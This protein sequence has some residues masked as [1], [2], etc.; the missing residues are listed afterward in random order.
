MGRKRIAV[1]AP[2]GTLYH[3]TGILNAVRCFAEA[4]YEVEIFT[5]RNRSF[6]TPSFSSES[7]A[8]RYMPW[9]F[10][11]AREPRVLVTV[12]FAL[13]M[14]FSIWRTR[15]IIFAG[16]VRGLIAAYVYSLFRRTRVINYQAEL[17]VDEVTSLGSR[18]FKRL[19]RAAARRSDLT[20]EHDERR[21]KILAS[22]LGVE[23]ERIIIVPNAPC[24]P[25]R[26]LRSTFLHDRLGI[27]R[28]EKILLCPGSIGKAFDTATAMRLA[29]M[30]PAGWRC[31]VHSAQPRS[32]NDPVI[33]QLRLLDPEGLVVFSLD[34][35]SYERIDEL[36][37]SATVGLVLYSSEAGTNMSTVG[38]SSGKLSHFLKLGIPVLVSPLEGLSD[39]VRLHGVGETIDSIENVAG[40]LEKISMDAE[41][42]RVRAMRCFDEHLSYA[43][44]FRRVIDAVA[45]W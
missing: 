13:W 24:G 41:G 23:P 1:F 4:G 19:E 28:D 45:S 9:T 42:Y 38:L 31:V 25:A 17:Y 8:V 5:I 32:V 40:L 22:D 37:G 34:P 20:I 2:M 21:G 33:Q 10:D 35:V 16:G 30:L 6:P 26:P 44:S 3:Q 12:L 27:D 14:G 18:V 7:V 39:F 11:S 36:L 43:Q 15:P 29:P